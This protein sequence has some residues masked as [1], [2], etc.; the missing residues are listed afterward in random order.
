M[1]SL[2]ARLILATVPFLALPFIYNSCQGGFKGATHFASSESASCKMVVEDGRLVKKKMGRDT[3]QSPFFLS[4][5]LLR[6]DPPS[7][8]GAGV[9]SKA[10]TLLQVSAGT[11]L[12]VLADNTCLKNLGEPLDEWPISSRL[13]QSGQALPDLKHQAYV[14]R[15]E[16]SYSDVELENMANQETCIEGLSWNRSYTLQSAFNDPQ[17]VQQVHLPSIAAEPAYRRFYGKSGGIDPSSAT[18]VNIAVVDSG[19]DWRH[20]DLR[21]HMWTHAKGIGIDIPSVGTAKASFDPHDISRNGHGTHVA[22][23]IG[24]VSN[25]GT[26]GVGTM[27][28]GVRIMAVKVFES[29][30]G[31][32]LTTTSQHFYNAVK[33]AYSNGAAVINLSL[34]ALTYASASDNVIRGALIEA[35][36]SGSTVVVALGNASDDKAGQLIDRVN[37]TSIPAIYATLEGV[38]SVGSYDTASGNKSRFSHYSTV[39]G[40]IA[41]PGAEVNTDGLFSTL[42]TKLGSYGKLAGTSQATPLVSAA[43]GLIVAAIQEAY[44]S[45]PTPAE[46][47][48]LLVAGSDRSTALSAQFK[49]GR[50]LNLETLVRAINTR[51]P[52]TKLSGESMLPIVKSDDCLD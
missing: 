26:G 38:I 31:V 39:F 46:V 51:Y 18:P 22:G 4:K 50:R 1:K 28:Y 23:L 41:A 35:V 2:N 24:A 14:W 9:F 19:V 40:E 15:L 44:G 10:T 20:P 3:S 29:I 43:A 8:L 12:V 7:S 6:P 17:I 34:A 32:N 42:P 49:A 16:Q 36:Q 37:L 52:K 33:Y 47:E 25:N 21:G 45:P 13:L 30:D 11:E 48:S 5:V 27:P